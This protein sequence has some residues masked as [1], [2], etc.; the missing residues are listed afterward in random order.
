MSNS[1]RYGFRL[2]R[3][4]PGFTAVAVLTLALGIGATSAIFSVVDA[5]LL[6]PL[7]LRDP[8]RL[9]LISGA[10]PSRSLIG[11]PFSVPAYETLRDG[12]RALSGVAAV[13]GERI[14]L[15]RRGDPEQLTA[16]RVSPEFFD[17]AGVRP[18]AGRGFTA[19][20]GLAGAPAVVLLSHGLWE[21]RFGADPAILGQSIVLGEAPYT[22]IGI[23]PPDF[24]FPY[25]DTDL[26]ITRIEDFPNLTQEQ[27]RHGG[28]FLTGIGRLAPGV[29]LAQAQAEAAALH[30]RYHDGHP[31][32]PDAGPSSTLSVEP[33]QEALV[34]G[35]RSTI[36]LLGAAVALV[37]LVACANV[38]GLLLARSVARAR[39]IAIRAALG[40]GRGALVRQLLAESVLLS[41]A[42]AA[43][44]IG[45]AEWGVF[46]LVRSNARLGANFS[47][48]RVDGPV[49]AFAVAVSLLTG[50]VFGLI[51]AFHASHPNLAGVLR[52][53][54]WGTT[55]GGGRHRLRGLLVAG[56]VA[57]SVVLLIGS[58]LLVESLWRIQEEKPGFDPRHA[59]TMAVSLPAAVYPDDA[60]RTD[61]VR[62]VLAR[63]AALPGVRSASASV[64][65]PFSI[66]V[67]APF[68]AEGQPA[69]PI[70]ERPLGEWKAITPDYFATLG[71]PL[72]RGR[73]FTWND[74]ADAPRRAI[75]S[76]S[77]A[78]RFWPNA[79]PIGKRLLYA[80]REYPAEVVG[81]AG[82]VKESG[83]DSGAGLVFYT[84]YPQFAWPN[85][86]FT[87]R[88]AG[89]PNLLANAARAQITATDR[90]LPVNRVQTLE[91][92]VA[93][94]LADRRQTLLL[95]AG[96]A[97]AAAILAL[98]GLYGAMAY[99]VTQRT[100]EIGIRQAIG[101][102]PSDI[103]WLVLAQGLGVAAAGV[104]VGL[105]AAFALT[106]LLSRMLF[107]TSPADPLTY[108]AVALLFLTVSLAATAIPAWRAARV[109]PLRALRG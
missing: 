17:V 104:G 7:P 59:L 89:D 74:G 56:Q 109:D 39:E 49:L 82:D 20:E 52:E 37:L 69:L 35:V 86:S 45:L 88:T 51:P 27:I 64:G 54:A 93:D 68:L 3:T 40:A 43:V 36:L 67:R 107:H 34:S 91:H 61:F 13:S 44:G 78:R 25:P 28:G 108:G 53:G 21:R 6:R 11:V 12:A 92:L 75:V 90:D 38:A 10:D 85:L 83:L 32:N 80:R 31:G 72:V 18:A 79:D 41:L 84:P 19:A 60:R 16:A 4:S 101:A 100:S 22:V 46:A 42:G 26:W 98:I 23:M 50:I 95:L 106:G 105:L 76:Q 47:Q 48:V 94:S 14:T 9:V 55:A 99:S 33:L 77:L 57:L 24:P 65:L 1:L 2:L 5:V 30:R 81:V 66:G 29:T 58:A 15:T 8:A 103:L 62:D 87:I 63:M 73:A 96:F 97:A 70:G 71:I 102:S